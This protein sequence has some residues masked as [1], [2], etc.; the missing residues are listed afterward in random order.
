[1]RWQDYEGSGY[2]T[3]EDEGYADDEAEQ[4]SSGEAAL[5]CSYLI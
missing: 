4:G 3:D 1:M 2:K 5:Q